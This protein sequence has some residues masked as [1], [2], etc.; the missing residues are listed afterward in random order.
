MFDKEGRESRELVAGPMTVVFADG[1]VRAVRLGRHEVV[2][3][4]YFALRDRNWGTVPGTISRLKV[5]RGEDRFLITYRSEHHDGGI[6]FLW[7][8]TIAGESNGTVRFEFEGEALSA[9]LRNRIG[10]CVLHPMSAAGD[11]VV[12]A[13][14]DGSTTEGMFPKLISPQQPFTEMSAIRHYLPD[15]GVVETRLEGE[16][17]EM[18]DQRNWTDATF[19]TY[20]TPLRLQFPVEV[21]AGE[22]IRQSVTISL[23]STAEAVGGDSRDEGVGARRFARGGAAKPRT[24]RVTLN[25]PAGAKMIPLGLTWNRAAEELTGEERAR[26]AALHLSHLHLELVLSDERCG[27]ELAAA[28]E[29]SRQIGAPL[30]I[31]LRTGAEARSEIER[32][33][34]AAESAR[35]QVE[36]WTV[37]SEGRPTTSAEH[38]AIARE[39]LAYWGYREPVGAGTRAF[40]AELNRNHLPIELLD[41]VTYTVNPQVHASD[42]LSIVETLGG[43]RATVESARAIAQGKPV[44][45]GPV[46]LK[47][48]WNPNATSPP[49][50]ATSGE[51]PS[52][53]DVRQ[54]LPFAA[55]WTLGSV[56][57]LS[58]AGAAGA[59]FYEMVG[60]KGV[61]ERAAG[62]LLPSL[63]P[64]RPGELFPLYH[65][66]AA[67]GEVAGGEL[68]TT[69]SSD[70]LSFDGLAVRKGSLLR[71]F[72]AS[73][74]ATE[75]RLRIEGVTGAFEL[76]VLGAKGPETATAERLSVSGKDME[77]VLGPHEVVWLDQQVRG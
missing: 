31:A 10:L 63:F 27:D 4:I 38:L 26:F 39:R 43:Q 19:K 48:Q 29:C 59:T 58:E 75:Q 47:M 21:R 23:L 18:E 71:C 66:Y 7:D 13:H 36:S 45:V 28:S 15:G 5:D 16:I 53:V 3:R 57:A 22:R 35:P 76:R 46:T 40:F 70:S 67:L 17:F 6:R 50:P 20:C 34:R 69:T 68:I 72:I 52:E 51:L 56:K 41:F 1:D 73:Y 74:A 49:A 11:R 24:A 14:P 55:A 65:L 64:S 44:H 61:T 2:N 60:W 33:L 54:R 12:V 9:F 37:L 30:S 32:L 42:E 25:S 62:S 77:L 8:A